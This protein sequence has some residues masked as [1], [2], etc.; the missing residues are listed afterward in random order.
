MFQRSMILELS[1]HSQMATLQIKMKFLILYQ[2][3]IQKF[4]LLHLCMYYKLI[5]I[6]PKHVFLYILLFRAC[7]CVQIQYLCNDEFFLHLKHMYYN[8]MCSYIF[9][10]LMNNFNNRKH[11]HHKYLEF[12]QK[13]IKIIH[14]YIIN[15]K[16]VLQDFLDKW[17]CSK[18]YAPRLKVCT[19]AQNNVVLSMVLVSNFCIFVALFNFHF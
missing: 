9:K 14:K 17:N 12:P 13:L 19:Y 18:F 3:G 5:C 10:E 11:Q 15:L 7:S 2:V 16:F 6:I 8:Q 1:N 4:D